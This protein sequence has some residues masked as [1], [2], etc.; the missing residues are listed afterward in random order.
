RQAFVCG[1]Q[2]VIVTIGLS[3]IGVPGAL[4][5][6]ALSTL[7][8]AIPYFGPTTAAA[9]PIAFCLVAFHG[10]EMALWTGGFFICLELFTNNVLDPRVLGEGAGLSPFGVILSAAFW[11]WLWGPVGLFVAIPLTACL[12]VVGRYVPQLAFVPAILG[13]DLVVPPAIQLY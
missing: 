3:L 4:V 5:F 12:T 9:L 13:R 10:F 1:L 11:A 8:R 6:G 7:L 2:G